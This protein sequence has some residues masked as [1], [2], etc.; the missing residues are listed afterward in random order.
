MAPRFDATLA[1][2]KEGV[3]YRQQA[4]NSAGRPWKKGK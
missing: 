2:F 1:E 3:G 4:A